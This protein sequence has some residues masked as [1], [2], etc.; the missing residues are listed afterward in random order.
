MKAAGRTAVPQIKQ[1]DVLQIK[2][3]AHQVVA[4]ALASQSKSGERRPIHA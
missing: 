1:S 2:E 3:P 4:L